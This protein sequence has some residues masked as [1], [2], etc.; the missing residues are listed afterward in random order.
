[1]AQTVLKVALIFILSLCGCQ[2]N[3]KMFT[4]LSAESTGIDFVNKITESDTLNA[5]NFSYL[6]HGAGVGIID[7]NQDGLPD[8]YFSANM[9]SG[10]LY[11]NKGNLHFEDITARSGLQTQRW[12]NGVTVADINQDGLPDIY[13]NVSHWKDSTRAANQLF[14]NQG[15]DENGIPV[16]SEQAAAYGLD[17][18]GYS[19]QSAFFDYDQDGDLDVYI[20]TNGQDNNKNNN[21]PHSRKLAGENANTDRLYRNEGYNASGH[22]VY[23]DV[24]EAAGILTEGYGLGLGIFD[25]NDDGWPDIYVSNDFISNDILW[26]NNGDGTY[27]NQIAQYLKHQSYNAMGV[28]IADVNNDGLE[29]IMVIDMLPEKNSRKKM[30]FSSPNYNKFMLTLGYGY[31]PE[32]VR[33]TLQLNQ[34]EMEGE[35]VRFSEIGQLAGV[36]QTDWS[37]APLLADFD[38]DGLKDLFVTNGYRRDVTDL[39]FIV[40]DYHTL[41][42]GTQEYKEKALSEKFGSLPEIKLDNYVFKNKGDLTFEDV[43]EDWGIKIPSFSNGAAYADLDRDGDLDIVVNN[44]DEPAFIYRNNAN[45]NQENEETSNHYLNIALKGSEKNKA[46]IGTKIK[47]THAGGIQYQEHAP[48]K[49]YLSTVEQQI[50]FGLGHT[51]HVDSMEIT[52]PDGNYQL[53]TNVP[54]DTLIL[55]DYHNAQRTH[56]SV[57]KMPPNAFFEERSDSLGIHFLHHETDFNDF[58]QQVLLPHKYSQQGPCIAVGD[59]DGDGLDDFYVGGAK[60]FAGTFFVQNEQGAFDTVTMTVDKEYEDV[61]ALLFD[62]DNDGDNDLYVV[63]GSVEYNNGSKWYQDRLYFNDG[64]GNFTLQTKALPAMYTSSSCVKAADFDQDGDLDLFVGGGIVPGHYPSSEKNYLLQNDKGK[65]TEVT[66]TKANG[67]TTTG[68]V[69]DALWSDF[70]NDGLVDL[71]VAGEWM[72]LTFL[73]NKGGELTDITKDTGIQSARGWWNSISSGDFDHDGDLDYVVGN[74]GLNTQYKV[75][76]EQPMQLFVKDFDENGSTDPVLTY[77]T[78]NDQGKMAPFV[79]PPRDQLISQIPAMKGVFGRYALYA[80]ASL[81]DVIPLSMQKGMIRKEATEFK[82]SYFENLGNG[83]FRIKALPVEAQLAPIYGIVTL[84]INQDGHPDVL[85]VGNSYAPEVQNGRYDAGVGNVLLGDGTGNFENIPPAE[86][87]FFVDGDAKALATIRHGQHGMLILA[88]CNQG[89]LKAF[90][91]TGIA[92]ENL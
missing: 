80:K 61:D 41:M 79:A 22:P 71:I 74:L 69:K 57:R 13:L 86:T 8:I 49:G 36:H 52:W 19:M 65:F 10:K 92:Y 31:E 3:S 15:P 6:Y 43:S 32:Y 58:A 23:K 30:M 16:F 28:D 33:N 56:K 40:Y 27:S 46:G 35:G 84:D 47:L 88:A 21:S 72:P 12:V 38:N 70:N 42:F 5:L 17:D 77:Y 25:V 83:K 20:L 51:T 1:M 55:I 2:E 67:L 14:I 50:H 54:S 59:V 87:H 63:S 85:T 81:E 68:P 18:T 44:M 75:S 64:K 4:I 66:A 78:M 62:A 29:D 73:E 76:E 39:D 60:G 26:V 37:W 45:P 90:Q 89:K 53:L 91:L 82:S 7:A 48:Y 9:Q 24:S 11:L 34:G